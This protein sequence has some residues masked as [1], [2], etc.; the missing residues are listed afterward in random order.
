MMLDAAE[1]KEIAAEQ[2]ACRKVHNDRA[3]LRRKSLG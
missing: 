2:K 3:A 1:L